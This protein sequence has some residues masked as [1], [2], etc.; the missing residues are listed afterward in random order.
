MTG[1]KE[2]SEVLFGNELSNSVS[3]RFAQESLGA[4]PG[5][6]GNNVPSG[7]FLNQEAFSKHLLLLGGIGTGKTNT[8][9][10]LMSL[11]EE[12]LTP[13]DVVVIFDTKGDF[14]E[15]F[16]RPGDVVFSNDEH[17]IGISGKN[18]WNIFNEIS[19]DSLMEENI[20]EIS[21]MLFA[22][23]CQK[24]NQI[25][26]PAAA[27]D[28]FSAIV[29]HFIKFYPKGERTNKHLI[30]YINSA[31][32]Q[33][34]RDMLL[35]YPSYRA[36]SSYISIDDS[37][38]TQG[39]LSELQQVSRDVFSGAFAEYGTLAI[40]DLVRQKGGRR[41]FVEYDLN[42]G[43]T[44]SPIYSLLFDLAIKEALGRT[45]SK[46]NVYFVTDE[47]RLL[48]YLEH[49]DDAV[50]FGRSLGV[51][52]LI[53]IQNVEQIYDNYGEERARSIM[54]GFSSL[55][56]FRVNDAKSRDF[57][58]DF[59][60]KNIKLERYTPTITTKG[61]IEEKR[62]AFVVEDWDLTRLKIG[63]AIVGF[64][65]EDPFKFHFNIFNERKESI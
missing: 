37:P 9:Y 42:L 56:A 62:E 53:G 11:I 46:G 47:F 8:M 2:E 24:T 32:S 27:R 40:R 60:G 4:I 13:D 25:F 57:V 14:Y 34:L 30:A 41:I 35:S 18:Y 15:R 20:R 3:M 44:L 54:S 38:Q 7:L 51:K 12:N 63:E 5:I 17:A 26:F 45:R 39:V 48:P 61:T 22:E 36:M 19:D 58:K 33:N 16:Y 10:H 1:R 49:I 64:P 50:N 52:F 59:F 23:A 65:G 21:K 55:F 31:T 28:I 43:K 6:S 29:M